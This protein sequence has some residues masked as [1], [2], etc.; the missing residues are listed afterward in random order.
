MVSRLQLAHK[1]IVELAGYSSH[2]QSSRTTQQPVSWIGWIVFQMASQYYA[3]TGSC[4]LTRTIKTAFSG[5]TV[6][7]EFLLDSWLAISTLVIGSAVV[8]HDGWHRFVSL[9]QVDLA[10]CSW[11]SSSELL[12][13]FDPW[14]TIGYYYCRNLCH[15]PLQQSPLLLMYNLNNCPIRNTGKVKL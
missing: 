6:P 11:S 5:F 7:V 8:G 15:S 2:T 12:L 10:T 3:M 9:H 4:A 1:C 13:W 14:A